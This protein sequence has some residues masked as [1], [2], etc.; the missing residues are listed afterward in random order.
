MG[1]QSLNLSTPTNL[2]SLVDTV[3]AE[4]KYMVRSDYSSFGRMSKAYYAVKKIGIVHPQHERF[5]VG[6]ALRLIG[7]NQFHS[8]DTPY[9]SINL[10]PIN[11]NKI[12]KLLKAGV[13]TYLSRLEY[14]E[15]E[16]ETR[17]A[18]QV[19]KQAISEAIA[20]M[21]NVLSGQE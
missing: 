12:S 19:S 8:T 5:L 2:S 20:A 18:H 10:T 16:G 13:Q 7:F 14:S 4:V 6:D 11:A 1:I 21:R 17:D 3:R 15:S 9:N